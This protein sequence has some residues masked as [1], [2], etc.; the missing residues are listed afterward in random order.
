MLPEKG[1]KRVVIVCFYVLLGFALLYFAFNYLFKWLWPIVA[2]ALIGTLLQPIIRF[3]K[4]KLKFKHRIASVLT[5]LL[6]YIGVGY[7]LFFVIYKLIA[8]LS[9]LASAIPGYISK[10]NI[11]LGNIEAYFK[12]L[13]E[14]LPLINSGELFDVIWQSISSSI[15]T[16]L[17]GLSSSIITKLPSLVTSVA[18][19]IPSLL[20]AILIMIISSV[21]FATDYDKIKSFFK[22]QLSSSAVDKIKSIKD[23]LFTTIIK[24]LRAYLLVMLITCVEIYLGLS[25][26]GQS[27][28]LL[29]A[30]LISIIDVLPVLGTGTVLIPWGVILIITGNTWKGIS[31]IV[32]YVLVTVIRQII[33]PKIVGQ[34]IGLYPLI[35][36]VAMYA[37][38]RIFGIVGMFLFPITIIILKELNQNGSIH[39]WKNPPDAQAPKEPTGA[40]LVKRLTKS[41][42]YKAEVKDRGNKKDKKDKKD[43][44]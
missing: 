17:S 15:F 20:L 44:K 23:H 32:L 3:L 12:T 29:L 4:N 21:Y 11:N 31:I 2:A 22:L 24:Y 26:L 18:Q 37:G 10:L 41:K 13:F 30:I 43:K 33:E 42:K 7:L 34:Y 1:Y 36:L 9:I 8:E 25:L 27:Y 38:L 39:L 28:A 14:N 35:T 5:V 6:L 40:R 16:G 19:L